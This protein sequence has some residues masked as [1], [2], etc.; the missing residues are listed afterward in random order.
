MHL[1]SVVRLR[2]D[3]PGK[4]AQI[5]ERSLKKGLGADGC[6]FVS[7]RC[8]EVGHHKGEVPSQPPL[9]RK[10]ESV[11]EHKLWYLNTAA[12]KIS[13]YGIPPKLYST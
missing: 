1:L 10:G 12:Y 11:P 6:G 4:G 5:C 7:V 13:Q 8:Y 2:T 3:L 9:G